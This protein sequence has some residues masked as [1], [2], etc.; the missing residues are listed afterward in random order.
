MNV[1]STDLKLIFCSNHFCFIS[2]VERCPSFRLGVHIFITL[3]Y[4]LF[5][6]IITLLFN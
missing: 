4:F 6:L 5:N 2:T 3:S 1:T